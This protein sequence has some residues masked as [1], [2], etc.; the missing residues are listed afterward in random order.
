MKLKLT[1]YLNIVLPAGSV[2]EADDVT[3]APAP[4]TRRKF[5]PSSF[6]NMKLSDASP[7][8]PNSA[9]MVGELVRQCT[10]NG[11]DIPYY[12]NINTTS[13]SAPIYLVK[14]P[15]TPK[16]PVRIVQNGAELSWSLMDQLLVKGIRIPE[17]LQVSPG[18]DGEVAIWDQVDDILYEFWQMQ[19]VNGAW[20]ASWGGWIPDVSNAE[21]IFHTLPDGEKIGATA[22]GLPLLGGAI[23]LDELKAGI[24][25]HCLGLA[26]MQGPNAWVWPAQRTDGGGPFFPGPNAIPAGTRFKFPSSIVI[27]P[28]WVPIVKMMVAAIRDYGCVVQDRAGAVCFY[29][30][31][32]VR[33]G[34]G[35][36]VAAGYFGGKAPWQFL[37]PRAFPFN[38]LQAL[39]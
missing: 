30:E 32:R 19:K 36:Q 22:T 26:I 5:A 12:P 2:I 28:T 33:F 24:I 25:P 15:T 13:Y 18:T 10:P 16:L 14:D 20:Q 8:H 1:K 4:A 3:A 11:A 23:L 21:G 38:K 6:Y 34:A 7:I 29:A 31:D 35:D 17:N 9:G 39:A 27:D 37:D